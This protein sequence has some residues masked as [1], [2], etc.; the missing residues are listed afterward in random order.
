[1]TSTLLIACSCK[2]ISGV[3]E[4]IQATMRKGIRI[5][6]ADSSVDIIDYIVKYGDI[7]LEC[8]TLQDLVW[9]TIRG[10]LLEKG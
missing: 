9:I 5:T 2:G 8:V 7:R 10:G 3:F 6:L 1:M 4:S